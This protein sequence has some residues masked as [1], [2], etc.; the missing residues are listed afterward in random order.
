MALDTTGPRSRRA[1]LAAAVGGLAAVAANAL[2][3]PSDALAGVDGDVV[4]GQTNTATT[5]TLIRNTSNGNDVVQI[6]SN[7]GTALRAESDVAYAVYATSDSGIAMSATS[8]ASAGV[9]GRAFNDVATG[10]T[11][12][13]GE[14]LLTG[15]RPKTGVYGIATQDGGSRGVWGQSIA[16]QG[17]RGEATTGRGVHGQATT[18]LGVRGFATSGVGLS[19]EATTGYALRANGRVRLDQ[20][21]GQ[22]SIASGTNSVVV[23]PGIDL[24]TTSAVVATLNGNAGGSTTVK[25]VAINTTA[26]T[27][28]IYLTA[29]TTAT[30][31][32]AWVV[33]G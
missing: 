22:A 14:V 32:A 2:G 13:S 15:T 31:K 19:G 1:I 27:F 23:T 4:L 21:A 30:V 29:N 20:S 11:G 3:R 9:L 12:V 7:S 33:L 16:G 6:T 28:T 25:R 5:P 8:L 26:N 18:G 17:V 24:T 10:V